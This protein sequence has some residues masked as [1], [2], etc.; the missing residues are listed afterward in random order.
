MPKAELFTKHTYT[1]KHTHI[2]AHTHHTH[3]HTH[4]HT[5]THTHTHT[6][7][8]TWMRGLYCSRPKLEQ[9]KDGHYNLMRMSFIAKRQ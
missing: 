3:T 6:N 7:T 8:H 4:V 2:H 5:H 9:G 1:H